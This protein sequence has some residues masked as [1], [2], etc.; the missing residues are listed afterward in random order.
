VSA[1]NDI[2]QLRVDPD[3]VGERRALPS[4]M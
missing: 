1:A 2:D 4:R 3:A